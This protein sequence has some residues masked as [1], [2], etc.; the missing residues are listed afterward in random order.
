MQRSYR[1]CM[2]A[3]AEA[4]CSTGGRDEVTGGRNGGAGGVRGDGETR[5]PTAATGGG[6]CDCCSCG[7][8]AT[9][10]VAAADCGAAATT[11]MTAPAAGAPPPSAQP[12]SP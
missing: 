2:A 7:C 5:V 10:G 6:A 8:G 9:F 3:G 12:S 4:A 1:G 11:R